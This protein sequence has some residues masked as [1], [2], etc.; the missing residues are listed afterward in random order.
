MKTV[1]ENDCVSLT[2]K[3]RYL[4]SCGEGILYPVV[5]NLNSVT[6]SLALF[7]FLQ[8]A[9]FLVGRVIKHNKS[10]LTC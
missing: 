7:M 8:A 10:K 6:D 1:H 4:N 3:R 9:Q 5:G 2:Q